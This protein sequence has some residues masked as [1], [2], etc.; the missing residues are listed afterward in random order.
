MLNVFQEASMWRLLFEAVQNAVL[1]SLLCFGFRCEQVKLWPSPGCP[2][3]L[4][5]VTAAW[6][7]SFG[8]EEVSLLCRMYRSLPLAFCRVWTCSS[9]PAPVY[10]ELKLIEAVLRF[11]CREF[12]STAAAFIVPVT[13]CQLALG[14]RPQFVPTDDF[15]LPQQ[16]LNMWQITAQSIKTWTSC[17]GFSNERAG[18]FLN[19]V[20]LAFT[21]ESF[22]KGCVRILS[23]LSQLLKSDQ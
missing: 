15:F 7:I 8:L 3:P 18:R 2:A 12:M 11:S 9:R 4:E 22:Y 19:A 5:M 16:S 20:L 6:R 10:Q 13:V 1:V 17:F 14:W 23:L 21:A